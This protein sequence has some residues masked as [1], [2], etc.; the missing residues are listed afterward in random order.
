MKTNIQK[1]NELLDFGIDNVDT[2]Y[3]KFKPCSDTVKIMIFTDFL[4]GYYSGDDENIKNLLVI[5]RDNR[6]K[7]TLKKA[8]K[9]LILK[10]QTNLITK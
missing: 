6:F 3:M 4:N 5:M 8:N 1:V 10:L 2:F 7:P 9:L